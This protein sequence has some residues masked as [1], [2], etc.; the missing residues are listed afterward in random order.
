MDRIALSYGVSLTLLE[1]AARNGLDM[2]MQLSPGLSIAQTEFSE[3]LTEVK[4]ILNGGDYLDVLE[5]LQS[6]SSLSDKDVNALNGEPYEIIVERAREEQGWR[7]PMAP[8]RQK[9]E[10]AILWVSADAAEDS[11]NDYEEVEY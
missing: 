8:V 2:N 9:G 10:A 1:L 4:Q 11:Q 3:L 6:G 7:R 5:R